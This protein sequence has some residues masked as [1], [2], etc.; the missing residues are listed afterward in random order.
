[1]GSTRRSF[2]Q[3]S[4]ALAALC[5]PA[6][7]RASSVDKGCVET[8]IPSAPAGLRMPA[9][10]H[11]HKATWMAY[12]ATVE[13][14]GDSTETA[15][16]RDLSNSRIVARQ[17]L[18]R[19]AANIS[20]FE[21]IYLLVNDADDEAQAR[22]LLKAVTAQTS[23]KDQ[24][25][26]TLDTSGRIYIGKDKTQS[27][28]PAIGTFEIVFVRAPL[29]DLWS[30]DS[31]PVISQDAAGKMV[32]VNLNFNGW[33]QWPLSSGVC[34]WIKDPLKTLAGVIDQPIER[35][36]K[37]ASFINTYTG[38][39]EVRTW[40]TAEG[41]CFEVNGAG[42]GM[43]MASSIINDNRNP[44]KSQQEIDAEL[45]RLFGIEHMIWMPGVKGEELTDWHIDFTAR[46]VS[47]NQIVAAFDRNFEPEDNRNEL[48]L[49]ASIE[50]INGLPAEKRARYLGDANAKLDLQMLPVPN[51]EKVYSSYK[52]RNVESGI[53]ERSLEEF[54]LTT[55]P[56]YIGYYHV[57]G[58]VIV[59]Q[60][61]DV[62]ADLEA[63]NS[64]QALYP[65]HL[66]IQIS[67]DG[68]ASGGGSIRCATQQ[69]PLAGRALL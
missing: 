24:F 69:Q 7:L 58:A 9:E 33:G 5:S 25:S 26:N 15:F 51:I 61:G 31:A 48:A 32:G 34:D 50:H 42:L 18:V 57:N 60:F 14:W 27:S 1:M 36:R 65:E 59:G 16:D 17:D 49:L 45:G 6:F 67:T 10:W 52:T 30:R 40:L 54:I 44:N 23:A 37:V 39:P 11:P 2:L 13:A 8:V 28:L 55:E 66:V 56:G 62:E 53:T 41:G 43:A 63:F 3:R 21:R 19:L 29:D 47:K 20:R 68:L 38:M 35:D 64:I 4:T 46:F 22:S 12:G